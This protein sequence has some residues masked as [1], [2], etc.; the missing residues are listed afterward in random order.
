MHG[1][2]KQTAQKLQKMGIKTI[3]ELALFDRKYLVR[4]LGKL[5][6]EL[7]QLAN[8]IDISTV[9]PHSRKDVK[10]IGKSTTLAHDISDINSAKIILM[11]LSDEVGMTARKYNKKGRTVQI[12][13][14]Y[15]NFQSITRQ[16]TIPA[17]YL[18]KEIYSA[19]IEMLKKN[20]N[21]QLSVRLLGISLSG[22][23]KDNENEQISMFNMLQMEHEKNRRNV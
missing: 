10:S 13:I 4:K 17:T 5:G 21:K 15:S 22:F 16:T 8:G 19:G 23:S 9:K 18:V 6:D 11:K 12:N 2:G 7:H 14:K 20:W 3:G 1:V